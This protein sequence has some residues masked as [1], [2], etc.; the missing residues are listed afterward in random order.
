V[1]TEDNADCTALTVLD[2]DASDDVTDARLVF[3]PES[4]VATAL[5]VAFSVFREAPFAVE[6]ERI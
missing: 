2:R 3:R 1:E 6:E 4:V 5:R